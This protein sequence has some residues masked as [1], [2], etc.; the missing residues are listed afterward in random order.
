MSSVDLVTPEANSAE[1]GLSPERR[2]ADARRTRWVGRASLAL[3]VVGLAAGALL[4]A[5]GRRTRAAG[6]ATCGASL[7]LATLRWQLQRLVTERVPYELAATVGEIELR[8]YPTEVRAETIVETADWN[9]ALNEGFRRL[10]RYIF[11]DNAGREH[12]SRAVPASSSWAAP[13]RGE[14]LAMTA[15]VLASVSD[16]GARGGHVVAFVMPADRALEELPRP[17]DPRV[18]LRVVPERLVAALRFRGRYGGGL[19]ARKQAELLER[20]RAA[21]IATRGEPSFAG[22]DPPSTL[23]WLRRNEVLVD[24]ADV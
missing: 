8:S 5:G 22:Y 17:R 2:A 4:L 20:L 21:G 15:P 9:T 19:P 6:L 18:Q 16:A 7:G 23:P 11:G 10:A 12:I 3:P 24:L 13:A 1:P 14:R